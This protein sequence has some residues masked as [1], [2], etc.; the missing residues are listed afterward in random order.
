MAI[1][2]DVIDGARSILNDKE[3]PYGYST[4]DLV[5]YL[6]DALAQMLLLRPDIFEVI[7]TFTCVEG[8]MQQLPATSK[9]IME[10][11]GV[12]GG[13]AITEVPRETLDM[14]S[15]NWRTETPGTP[16]NWARHPRSDRTFFLYPP[17]AAGTELDIQHSVPVPRI[18]ED[19]LDDDMAVSP[20][21]LPAL[22]DYVAG[23]AE[24][25]N[26]EH[27]NDQRAVQLI[28][29]FRAA[30]GVDQASKGPA[31]REDAGI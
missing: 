25:R 27:A 14:F 30:L 12:N 8:H 20:S 17:A 16:V 18:T 21:Y 4:E 28:G 29:E 1:W 19:D 3:Q 22:V 10:V 13:A 2:Q 11:L 31:D 26:D 9:R 23:R 15:P 5:G 24:M 7:G 6:N